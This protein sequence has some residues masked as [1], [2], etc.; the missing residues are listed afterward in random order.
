MPSH[1]VGAELARQHYATGRVALQNRVDL[2]AKSAALVGGFKLMRNVAPGFRTLFGRG[3]IGHQNSYGAVRSV[4][5]L[6]DFIFAAPQSIGA[7]AY[8][9]IRTR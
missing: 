4:A 3:N 8:V 7:L 9:V 6:R 1:G 5:K 2:F